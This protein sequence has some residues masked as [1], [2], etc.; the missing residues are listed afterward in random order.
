MVDVSSFKRNGRAMREGVWIKPGPEFGDLEIHTRGI[1][2]SFRD[3][4][5]AAL[6]TAARKHNGEDRIPSEVRDQIAT[7]ALISECL[8]DVRGLTEAGKPVDFA[9]YCDMLRDPDYVELNNAA[10]L[11]A[12]MASRLTDEDTAAAV[13]NSPPASVSS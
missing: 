11:A 1:G 10:F 13:G 8:R 5:S 12:Q 2:F 6:R 7:D 3:A 4:Q 9:R